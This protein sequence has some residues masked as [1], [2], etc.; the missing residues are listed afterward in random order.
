[1]ATGLVTVL[2]VEDDKKILRT[3][4]RILV[5]NGFEVLCAGT[6]GEDRELLK[7][8]RQRTEIL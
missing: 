8:R 6:L 3:N 5:W 2:L 7:A 4:R 1:M